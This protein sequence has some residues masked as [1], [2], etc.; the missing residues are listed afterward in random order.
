[1]VLRAELRRVVEGHNAIFERS[2]E[3]NMRA[4]RGG[5]LVCMVCEW[6]FA[7]AVEGDETDAE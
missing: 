2:Q 6:V 7:L 3:T 1:M 5:D 4:A